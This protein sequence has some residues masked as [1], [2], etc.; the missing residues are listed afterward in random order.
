[1]HY[2]FRLTWISTNGN[3]YTFHVD[4]I[5]GG[6]VSYAGNGD[7]IWIN[8]DSLP[9]ISDISG[10]AQSN[11]LNRRVALYVVMPALNWDFPISKNPFIAGSGGG[12][13]IGAISRGPLIDADQYSLTIDIFDMIGNLVIS[14]PMH[15]KGNGWFY[16]WDGR[17]RNSRIVGT[18]VYSAIIR[19]YKNNVAKSTKRVRIGVK[20]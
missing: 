6:V 16:T 18:G 9:P 19:I 8:T 3:S 14:S 15:P 7:S 11:P 4:A 17:N 20:R 13:E 12:S 5:E 10:C 1:V 2:Q